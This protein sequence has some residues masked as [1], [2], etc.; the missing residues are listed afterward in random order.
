L[1]GR[2]TLDRDRDRQACG[3][4]GRTRR[5]RLLMATWEELTV[6]TE[7][8]PREFGPLTRTD[9]VRYQGASGD[10]NPI[11]HDDDFAQSAGYPTPCSSRLRVR[12]QDPWQSRRRRGGHALTVKLQLK[13]PAS[14]AADPWR[15]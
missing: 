6:G 12:G 4:E 1:G 11:H 8:A 7:C 9:F 10:F 3:R 2:G 13:L 15:W 14:A 5:R